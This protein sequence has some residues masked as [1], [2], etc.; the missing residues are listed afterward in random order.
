MVSPMKIK[1]GIRVRILGSLE[2]NKEL[3][4]DKTVSLLCL[5]T[6]FNRKT[7]LKIVENMENVAEIVVKDGKILENEQ[8]K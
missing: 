5:D 3:D 8:K 7:V 1:L 2:A 6:G 4:F